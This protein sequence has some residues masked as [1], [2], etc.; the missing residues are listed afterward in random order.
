MIEK[1]LRI[2]LMLG[3]NDTADLN[4]ML[5]KKCESNDRK[6]TADLNRMLLKKCQSNKSLRIWLIP[7]VKDTA[8]LNRMP[9]LRARLQKSNLLKLS[10]IFSQKHYHK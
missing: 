6:V 3:V 7:G 10:R 1:S 5:L 9:A 2:W 8:D 4:R